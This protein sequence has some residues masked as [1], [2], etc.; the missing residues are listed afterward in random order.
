MSLTVHPTD[1]QAARADSLITP[2]PAPSPAAA[3]LERD[4]QGWITRW[5]PEDTE[6]WDNTGAS[7]AKRNLTFSVF[8]EHIGFCIWSLWSVLVLF[9]G[10]PYGFD[11]SQKFLLTTIP[12][13]VGATLRIPYTFA[14]AKF[15]GRNFT[16]FSSVVLLVPLTVTA[17]VLKPGVS[18]STLLLT[19]ALAGVGGGNFSSSMSNIDAFYP[20]RLKGWALGLNAGGG[21]LGVASVQL[22]GL[23]VLATAGA[24]HPRYVLFFYIPL[25]VVAAIGAASRMDNLRTA[26]NDKGAMRDAI[27]QGHSWIII[28]L[29]LASFGSFIGFG[30]AFG[31]VLLTQFKDQFA[32]PADAARLTIMGPLIGSLIRPYGG[33]LAD[34]FGGSRVSLVMF[35]L[36]TI[37]AGIIYTASAAGSLP[38]FITGFTVLFAIT[39]LANGSVYKMIPSIFKAKADL[40]VAAGTPRV[41]ADRHARKLSR[42]LIGIAGAT[43][44]FGGVLVILALRQS[45]LTNGNG[46]LAYVGFIAYYLLCAAVTWFTYVR[47]SAHR[48]EGV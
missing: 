1:E 12:T 40:A 38:V 32:T 8:S 21:N 26:S 35:T 34:R 45:F 16:I 19:A 22:V 47:K 48:L 18:F 28:L 23:I 41:D 39:G 11:P 33:K 10:K 36:M 37:G 5:E 9:L 17:I 43:G 3:E 44:A 42:A 6:F 30:F 31:Q 27:K 2:D 13:L 46:E 20:Q 14:T 15:G 7:V 24:T 29:Y 25:V 4:S